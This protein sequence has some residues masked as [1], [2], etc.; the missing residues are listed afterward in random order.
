VRGTI[1]R[2]VVVAVIAAAAVGGCGGMGAAP[3]GQQVA[4]GPAARG[5]ELYWARGC[6]NCHTVDGGM[7]AGP[8]LQGLWGSRIDLA[9]G[10]TVTANRAYIVRSLR[11]P[12]AQTADG[13]AGSMPAYDLTDD[14]IDDLI[15]YLKTLDAP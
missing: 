11:A 10:G 2:W 9:D 4:D 12:T 1:V 3:L 7:A 6:V 8:T 5:A 14:E 13:F 15:A